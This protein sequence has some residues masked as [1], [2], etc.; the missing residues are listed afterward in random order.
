VCGGRA[1]WGRF[2]RK[3]FGV[4]T[5]GATERG[6]AAMSSWTP[7]GW[8]VM[9]G[10]DWPWTWWGS[11]GGEDFYLEVQSRE[12]RT[13]FQKILRGGWVA[14]ARGDAPINQNWHAKIPTMY[15]PNNG[16]GGLWSALMLYKA[17]IVANETT[18]MNR[19]VPVDGNNKIDALIAR[20]AEPLPPPAPITVSPA[21]TIVIP[22]T[23]YTSVVNQSVGT[24]IGPLGT[25]PL[26]NATFVPMQS[27]LEGEQ[28][29]SYP[30]ASGSGAITY[31]VTANATALFYLTA[32]FTTFH[33]D[34]DLYVSVNGGHVL[35]VPVYYTVGW[36]NQTQPVAVNL[37]RGSNTL[38]FT[39]NT[40]RELVFKEFF[41]YT[42]KPDVPPPPGNY[43]PHPD[44]APDQYIEVPASTTCFQQGIEAVPEYL[45]RSACA[46][47]GFTS[48]GDV[49][50]PNISG[51][52]VET[53]GATSGRCEYNKNTSATCTPPC[54]L[55]GV[56]VRS[57]C[58]RN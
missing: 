19:S 46:A 44:P 37:S 58:I 26:Y 24:S 52:F 10:S 49:N 28:L 4:P 34:Q 3:G 33:M 15:S 13:E 14:I 11:R 8:N 55:D 18:P 23:A 47:L 39:R 35:S 31:K 53:T 43:T 12:N 56:V 41:L 45:C 22:A 36:W 50:R 6:H 17:K 20:C 27:F 30:N 2:T 57:I 16:Q 25:A 5:W 51:C 32:N 21:G 7:T 1:F 29:L 40:T 9:L 54:M 42:H 38:T 48:A